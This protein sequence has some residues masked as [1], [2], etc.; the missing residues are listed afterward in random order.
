MLRIAGLASP[1][2][3]PITLEVPGGCCIVIKGP[4]GA[5][6]SLLLR[7]IADLDPCEGRVSWM[8]LERHQMT[9]PEWRG[10]VGLVPATSGWWA[11]RVGDHFEAGATLS[12]LLD[13]VGLPH[14]VLTWDVARLSTG[15]R[16][17][18]AL[19]R[20][21]AQGPRALLLDEPTAALDAGSAA[22]V[23]ALL[24]DQLRGGVAMIVVT[25]DRDQARR[26]GNSTQVATMQHGRLG[27]PQECGR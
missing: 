12:A 14:D 3:G 7:A 8:S 21:I 5:G 20:A 6:K 15:E 1:R 25:H 17:R 2:F 19:V 27:A 24:R 26:L 13:G 22:R 18:L 23:E 16:H 9:A 11:D 4:S 10:L